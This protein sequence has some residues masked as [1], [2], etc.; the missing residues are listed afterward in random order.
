M[1]DDTYLRDRYAADGCRACA[2][3]LGKTIH[4][5]YKQAKALGLSYVQRASHP[6]I[7]GHFW[8]NVIHGAKSRG[9]SVHITREDVWQRYL[10]QGGRCALTG[11]E[12]RFDKRVGETTASVDRIDSSKDYTLDNI[13]IVHKRVNA[14]KM[15]SS[16]GDFYAMCKAI[17]ANKRDQFEPRVIEWEWDVWNDTERP[18]HRR[19]SREA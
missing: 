19:T 8:N 7:S 5:V 13:Q 10:M 17:H 18:V 4:A 9:I 11:W 14:S 2:V 3:A 16:D 6:H 12:I 15:A 1:Q